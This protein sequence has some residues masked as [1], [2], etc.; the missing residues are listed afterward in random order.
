MPKFNANTT[1]ILGLGW[2]KYVNIKI[3]DNK[4]LTKI[5]VST[6]NYIVHDMHNNHAKFLCSTK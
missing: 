2:F 4:K 1:Y 6:H 5:K 3:L